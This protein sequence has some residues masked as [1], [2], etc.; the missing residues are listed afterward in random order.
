MLLDARECELMLYALA[1]LANPEV[2]PENPQH[3][4]WIV[5]RSPRASELGP[6]ATLMAETR[7]GLL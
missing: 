6:L 7:D 4:A 3:A 5:W 1:A 2:T